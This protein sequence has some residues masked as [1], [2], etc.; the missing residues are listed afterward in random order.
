MKSEIFSGGAGGG[1]DLVLHL[2]PPPRPPRGTKHPCKVRSDIF[3]EESWET[4]SENSLV[5]TFVFLLKC[6]KMTKNRRPAGNRLEA[7]ENSRTDK[8]FVLK[9]YLKVNYGRV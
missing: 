7:G 5:W 1:F 4:L 9:L 6:D 8:T 2:P 3:Q